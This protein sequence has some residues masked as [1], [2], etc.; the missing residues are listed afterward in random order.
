[1]NFKALKTSVGLSLLFLVVYGGSNWLTSQRVGIG[2]FYFSWERKIPFVPAMI[3]PYMSIDLFFVA[4][5]FFCRDD[6]QRR[7]LARRM[8]AAILIS[9]A[10][11][12]AFPLRFAFERPPV[13]GFLGVIFNNFRQLDR[14]FNQ[15]PSLHITLCVMLG[16][17]FWD[18][19]RGVMRGAILLWFV[20]IAASTVLTF[21]HHVIDVIGGLALAGICLYLFDDEPMRMPVTPNRR[22]GKNYALGAAALAIIALASGPL[23]WILLWPALSMALMAAAYFGVGP[24]IFRKRY[25]KISTIA[26]LALGPVWLGQRISLIHYSRQC[27]NWHELTDRVWIGRKLSISESRRAHEAG[28]TAVLDLTCEFSEAA[29]FR[30]MRYLQLPIMDLTAPT[31]EQLHIAWKFIAEQSEHGIVYVHCKAGFS[32]TAA[33]A[34]A[35]LLATG[36]A[37]NAQEV[38]AILKLRSALDHH[39]PRNHRIAPAIQPPHR[40]SPTQRRI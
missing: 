33:A 4:A 37:Q 11:F 18:R 39:P 16:V 19:S 27:D 25:G 3:L 7:T 15:F 1:M 10:C 28:V 36:V 38:V 29:P 20:L 9:G 8:A 34:G 21:Q 26:R 32:R 22:V 2:S 6:R 12:L 17:F 13:G 30:R 23:G 35:F 14:P 40:R 24:G 5:P 31:A